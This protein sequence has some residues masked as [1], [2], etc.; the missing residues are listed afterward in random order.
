MIITF[1]RTVYNRGI[2]EI[3][4]YHKKGL[5][6]VPPEDLTMFIFKKINEAFKQKILKKQASDQ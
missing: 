5:K 3:Q 4:V 1:F 2:F 6:Y